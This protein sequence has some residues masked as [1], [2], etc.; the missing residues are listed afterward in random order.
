MLVSDEHG[1]DVRDVF[2]DQRETPRE[3]LQAQAGVQQNARLVRGQQRGVAGTAAGKRAE[4]DDGDSSDFS[5]YTGTARN[6]PTGQCFGQ[7]RR[8]ILS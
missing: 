1:V 8:G 6:N 4:F 2:A 5:E 3:L 7:P